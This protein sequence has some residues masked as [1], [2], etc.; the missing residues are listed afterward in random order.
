MTE[1]S[2][3][4]GV[5][6]ELPSGLDASFPSCEVHVKASFLCNEARDLWLYP[7]KLRYCEDFTDDY[8]ISFSDFGRALPRP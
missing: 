8:S 7:V 6:I 5:R 2:V 3:R 4:Q 1:W